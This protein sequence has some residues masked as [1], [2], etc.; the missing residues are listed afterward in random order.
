NRPDGTRETIDEDGWLHTGDAA[1]ADEDG[2]VWI[3]DRVG[4][5][6]VTSGGVV[7]P[8]QVERVLARHPAV[9]E[10]GVVGI[11]AGDDQRGAAFV[12]P[13]PGAAVSEEEL[14]VFS[15]EHLA[16]HEVPVS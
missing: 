5:R 10:A 8:G 16:P 1:M 7:Y 15:G 4:D 12:V 11:P 2:D 9:V 6:Y 3:V 14:L 13:G